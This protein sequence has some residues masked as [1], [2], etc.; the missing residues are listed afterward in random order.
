MWRALS[1]CPAARDI[2]A[3][4]N[5]GGLKVARVAV[6]DVGELIDDDDNERERLRHIRPRFFLCRLKDGCV[7]GVNIANVF[8]LEDVVAAF[9]LLSRPLERKCQ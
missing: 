7:I 5:D 8:R 1:E 2:C 6:H 4:P 3:E 9:H